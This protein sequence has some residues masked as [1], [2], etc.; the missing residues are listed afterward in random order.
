MKQF[1]SEKFNFHFMESVKFV[2]IHHM[3]FKWR[4]FFISIRTLIFL[5]LIQFSILKKHSRDLLLNGLMGLKLGFDLHEPQINEITTFFNKILFIEQA[6]FLP[7]SLL[8]PRLTEMATV[9]QLAIIFICVYWPATQFDK[10]WFISY[11]IWVLF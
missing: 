5:I 2:C 11:V 8:F 3:I 9:F 4:V 6:K 1:H 7:Y 10:F